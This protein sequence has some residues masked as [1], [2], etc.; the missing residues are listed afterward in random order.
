MNADN[1]RSSVICFGEI[2][3]HVLPDGLQGGTTGLNRILVQ[4]H[5]SFFQNSGWEA[6]CNYRRTGVPAFRGGIGV[7]NKGTIPKRW[8]YPAR[9]LN[10]NGINLKAALAGHSGGY[11]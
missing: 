8:T 10:R 9:E 4:K 7:G 11:R 6:Y 2:L 3:W 5:L 1:S